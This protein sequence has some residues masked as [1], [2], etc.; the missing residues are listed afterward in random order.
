MTAKTPRV[1]LEHLGIGQKASKPTK[2]DQKPQIRFGFHKRDHSDLHSSSLSV[3]MNPIQ[4]DALTFV[5][6]G[7]CHTSLIHKDKS[8]LNGG[9]VPVEAINKRSAVKSVPH[10]WVDI[11]SGLFNAKGPV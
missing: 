11:N 8:I 4:L 3:F 6:S 7:Q 2:M 10:G 1:Y 5:A 9:K